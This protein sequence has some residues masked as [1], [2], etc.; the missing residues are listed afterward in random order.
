VGQFPQYQR[1]SELSP[2]VEKFQ[3]L[4]LTALGLAKLA[5]SFVAPFKKESEPQDSKPG[6]SLV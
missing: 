4:L 6:A 1:A 3:A 2:N 5:K